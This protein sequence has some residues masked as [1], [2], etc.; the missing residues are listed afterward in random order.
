MVVVSKKWKNHYTNDQNF[1]WR[2]WWE[3]QI[4]Y[5]FEATQ[6]SKGIDFKKS[7]FDCPVTCYSNTPPLMS[8]DATRSD[9]HCCLWVSALRVLFVEIRKIEK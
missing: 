8:A 6:G 2:L 1:V 4:F 3:K 5:T 7:Q 9:G